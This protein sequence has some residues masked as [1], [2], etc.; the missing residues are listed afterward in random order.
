MLVTGYFLASKSGNYKF[1]VDL[2]DDVTYM[3]I[4]DGKA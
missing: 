1:I 3:N 2:V 4:G